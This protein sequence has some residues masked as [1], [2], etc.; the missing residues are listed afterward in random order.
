M[1]D[2]MFLTEDGRAL[3]RGKRIARR[4]EVA[5]PCV[6]WLEDLPETRYDGLVLDITPYGMLLRMVETLPPGTP[7]CVQLLR[8]DP[9]QTPLA[10]PHVGVIV[11]TLPGERFTRHGVKLVH[12][13]LPKVEPR[14]VETPKAAPARRRSRPRMHTIDYT[15]GDEG[16]RRR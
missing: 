12:K 8:D 15:V 10:Q 1:P 16:V 6:V 11:R 4:T 5:R 3:K 7:V 13:E 9:S 14:R 2:E